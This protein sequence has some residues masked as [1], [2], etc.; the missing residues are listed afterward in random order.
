MVV[1]VRFHVSPSIGEQQQQQKSNNVAVVAV[2][3]ADLTCVFLASLTYA[4]HNA[5]CLLA[6]DLLVAPPRVSL[7]QLLVSCSAGFAACST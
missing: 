5:C 1:I 6:A 3:V 7:M 2:C 4:F